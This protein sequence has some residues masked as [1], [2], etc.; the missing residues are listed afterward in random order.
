MQATTVQAATGQPSAEWLSRTKPPTGRPTAPQPALPA[1]PESAAGVAPTAYQAA[2]TTVQPGIQPTALQATAGAADQVQPATCSRATRS[3]AAGGDG[4]GTQVLSS[5]ATRGRSPGG[6]PGPADRA[7]LA[8]QPLR[9]PGGP[10]ARR[11][12]L[13]GGLTAGTVVAVAAIAIIV[14][15]L[16]GSPS[17]PAADLSPTAPPPSPTA[18]SAG[19]HVLARRRPPSASTD[20]DR[21]A[22][23]RHAVGAVLHTAS[24]PLAGG[25]V[26][27][28]HNQQ[29]RGVP[30][31]GRGVRRRR[32]DQRRVDDLVQRGVLRAAPLAVRLQ[33]RRGPAGHRG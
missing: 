7:G 23:D 29:R 15:S 10:A 4:A 26:L 28:E 17:T 24:V 18:P 3:R 20:R 8:G 14:S 2:V 25:R 12:R 13:I 31:D 22:A 11:R 5:A 19:G 33:R 27:P 1:N 30:L 6:P 16:G 21:V 32:A 9:L